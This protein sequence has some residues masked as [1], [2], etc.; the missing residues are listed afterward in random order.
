MTVAALA[1]AIDRRHDG[2]RLYSRRCWRSDGVLEVTITAGGDARVDEN[3]GPNI[4]GIPLDRMS[5]GRKQR[6]E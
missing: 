5:P 6:A 2:S 4:L 1:A 3:K